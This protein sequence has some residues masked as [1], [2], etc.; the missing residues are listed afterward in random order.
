LALEHLGEDTT[1][2]DGADQE[3]DNVPLPSPKYWVHRSFLMF[4][5]ADLIE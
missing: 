3:E 1:G 5:N 4:L 2:S